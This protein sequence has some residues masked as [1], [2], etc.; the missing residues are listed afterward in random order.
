MVCVSQSPQMLP[1]GQLTQR[2]SASSSRCTEARSAN[3]W[4]SG[5]ASSATSSN[6]AK[7]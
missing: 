2:S 7:R 4:P 3:G 1:E 5:N 6:I